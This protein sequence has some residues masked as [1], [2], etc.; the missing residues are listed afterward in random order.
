MKI[1]D[2]ST[3]GTLVNVASMPTLLNINGAIQVQGDYA[4]AAGA[5]DECY[6]LQVIHFNPLESARIDVLKK[7][8]GY[9]MDLDLQSGYLYVA[10]L[11]AGLSVYDISNPENP[12][13]AKNVPTTIETEGISVSGGYAYLSN[14][15]TGLTIIDI[16]PLASAHVDKTFDPSSWDYISDL[17]SSNGYVYLAMYSSG[18]FVVDAE[19]PESASVVKQLDLSNLQQGVNISGDYAY[20]SGESLLSIVNI[21]PPE[22]AYM[23]NQLPLSNA[24]MKGLCYSNGYVYMAGSVNYESA[25]LILDVDP[26]NSLSIISNVTLPPFAV[27]VNIVDNYAFVSNQDAGMRIVK[28]W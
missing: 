25:L 17:D 2:I 12:I 11:V 1:F 18:L 3:P 26:V 23:V 20:L 27:D 10:D 9:P 21:N 28:L 14:H 4:F 5:R 15:N 19:P 13:L 6:G 7:T 22:S 16:E 8:V 24:S